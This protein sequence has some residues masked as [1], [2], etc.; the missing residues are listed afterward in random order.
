MLK[1][2]QGQSQFAFI[3]DVIEIMSFVWQPNTV[4]GPLVIC[5]F[6]IPLLLLYFFPSFGD[7]Y[8]YFLGKE[9]LVE[10]I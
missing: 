4:G 8:I 7:I 9:L 10:T 3:Q 1:A 5:H 2:T 6:L